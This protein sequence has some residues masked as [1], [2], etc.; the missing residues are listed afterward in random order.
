MALPRLVSNLARLF[1][2][3]SSAAVLRMLPER[4]A[5]RVELQVHGLPELPRRRAALERSR[6]WV[7]YARRRPRS[8]A[9]G[10]VRRADEPSTSQRDDEPHDVG[11]PPAPVPTTSGHGGS[12]EPAASNALW[13]TGNAG[14]GSDVRKSSSSPP[15]SRPVDAVGG[16][17]VRVFKHE[18]F[19][20]HGSWGIAAKSIIS[21]R[22]K[23]PRCDCWIHC[24]RHG[25]R[26]R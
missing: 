1:V 21:A 6:C 2:L 3:F 7:R 18:P 5:L 14:I 10:S 22:W 15:V 16:P 23:S 17:A 11:S 25:N 19:P 24:Q 20:L 8:R 26:K 13:I 4:R 12:R 9:A